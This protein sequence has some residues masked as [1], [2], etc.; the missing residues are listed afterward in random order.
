MFGDSFSV[1]LISDL[2]LT[3]DDH[4]DWT[5]RQTSMFCIV[6]GNIS[7]D[8]AVIG[9]VLLSLSHSYKNILYIDG[10][11]E[12]TDL[13]SYDVRIMELQELCR[14]IPNVVFMH[15]HVV[16]LGDIAFV[17]INGWFNNRESVNS[18][19]EL[20]MVNEYRQSDLAY[21]SNT[22]KTLQLH[23]DTKQIAVISSCTPSKQ[24]L[25]GQISNLLH[26]NLEP[27]MVLAA[28]SDRKINTWMY[29]GSNIVTDAY[30]NKRRYV[31]NPK[32]GNQPYWPKKIV[33]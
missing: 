26:K 13:L 9:K 30:I 5:D 23:L 27:I 12:H 20:M 24:M 10:S 11:L 33:L 1:D 16:I 8:L 4:F 6:A 19:E 15:N 21:L 7:D 28:D 2:K 32:I 18:V 25:Y 22:I 29:G 17:A 31:N 3:A 14:T